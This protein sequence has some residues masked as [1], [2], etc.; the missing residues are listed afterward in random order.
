MVPAHAGAPPAQGSSRA[1]ALPRC[2]GRHGSHP[3][4]RPSRPPPPAVATRRRRR[5]RRWSLVRPGPVPRQ[6][7]CLGRT[8]VQT[9]IAPTHLMGYGG[10][11]HAIGTIVISTKCRL[12]WRPATTNFF[13]MSDTRIQRCAETRGRRLKSTRRR[14]PSSSAA[15]SFLSTVRSPSPHA[16]PMD[17][18]FDLKIASD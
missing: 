9:P 15:S 8:A 1:A 6:R 13:H 17:R 16:Q 2:A 14:P 7:P 10:P 18:H 11:A 3:R 4:Q 12:S 5:R